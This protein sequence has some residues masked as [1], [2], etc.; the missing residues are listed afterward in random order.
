MPRYKTGVMQDAWIYWE[1]VVEAD[2]KEE[3]QDIAMDM[4]KGRIPST[5]KE[6]GSNGFDHADPYDLEEIKKTTENEDEG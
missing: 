5:L 1:T 3:A 2:S 4:W 6:A